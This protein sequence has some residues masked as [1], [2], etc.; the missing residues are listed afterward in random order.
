MAPH[1]PVLA[2]L[3]VN[4]KS[5]VLPLVPNIIQSAAITQKDTLKT[6]LAV[7]ARYFEFRPAYLHKT[8]RNTP[9]LGDM[10]DKLYFMHGP[11]P[12]MS[13]ATFLADCV[14]FLARNPGEIIVV[15]LRWDG[16]PVECARPSAEDLKSVL[17]HTLPAT[18]DVRAGNLDDMRSLTIDQLRIQKKRL[19]ILQDID[20]YSIYSDEGNATLN[21]DSIIAQFEKISTNSQREKAFTNIQCQA[22]ATN[23]KKIWF[24]ALSI[25]ASNSWLL[26]TKAICDSKTLPWVRSRALERLGEDQLLVVMDDFV[27][28][29]VG[30]VCRELSA[31]RLSL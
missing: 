24:S 1:M 8:I 18:P 15:Q 13:Y 6:V 3:P 7:G 19:I 27:D 21:G 29:A 23:L 16:V 12:G 28:G 31:K 20:H 11:I 17:D 26:C 22:T 30:D 25:T 2:K 10:P 9:A 14:D 5:L 4:D